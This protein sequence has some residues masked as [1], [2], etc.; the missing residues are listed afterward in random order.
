MPVLTPLT[1]T[2]GFLKATFQGPPGSG[3]TYTAALLAARAHELRGA[4]RPV[5]FFDTEGG[6]DHVSKMIERA[7]GIKP[8][9]IKSRSFDLLMDAAR[10]C[11]AGAADVLIVDSI[12]HVWRELAEAYKRRAGRSRLELA[13]IMAIKDAWQPWPDWFC[14]APVDVIVCGRE[15]DE[16]GYE[17][18]EERGKSALVTTGKKMKVEKEFGFEGSLMVA[19]ERVE[20]VARLVKRKGAK[21]ER[22]PRGM[23]QVATVLKDRTDSMNGVVIRTPKGSDFDPHLKALHPA[24]HKPVDVVSRSEVE[25]ADDGEWGRERRQREILAE[26]IQGELV[27]R[28]PGRDQAGK[29]A[30]SQV[31]AAVFKTRSWTRVQSM[32]AADL[33]DGLK[34]LRALLGNAQALAE[35]LTPPAPAGCE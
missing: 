16:W 33:A 12:T 17:Y 11:S 26:E 5:A 2:A 24:G 19:F 10:E 32:Q 15:G 31:L 28:F 35:I 8:I 20:E 27:A 7:T 9:G 3:K 22:T 25:V 6:S 30:T 4:K 18:D 1:D 29:F 13:D 21:R 23:V 34:R 14:T